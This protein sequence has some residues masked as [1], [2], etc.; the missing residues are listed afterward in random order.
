MYW[1]DITKQV[2]LPMQRYSIK[3]LLNF[4]GPAHT[5][6]FEVSVLERLA[7]S[8]PERIKSMFDIMT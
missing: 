8:V 6:A 1:K 5:Q 2:V 3:T 4:A 7:M